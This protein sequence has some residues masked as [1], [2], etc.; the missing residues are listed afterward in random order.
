M[1][2]FK[3]VS[4]R[5]DE[6]MPSPE[7]LDIYR[8]VVETD[9]EIVALADSIRAHGIQ[10]PLVITLDHYILSGHRRHMAARLAG[11]REVPC[12]ILP[13]R[14]ADDLDRY[15]TQLREYNRQRVKTRE[16]LL[17]EAAIDVDPEAAYQQLS[18][19]RTADS[20]KHLKGR[21]KI[22]G[23]KKRAEISLA[24]APMLG[25]VKKIIFD[26]EDHWPLS[27]R[28]VHYMA[29]NDPPLRHASKPDS[30]YRNDRPSY[31]ALCDLLVRARLL[32]IIPWDAISDDTRP[33]ETW[34]IFQNIQPYVTEELKQFCNTYWRD[35]MQS[36]PDHIEIVG[37]KNTLKGTI[38]RTSYQFTIPYTLGRGYCSLDPRYEMAERYRNS[39][40]QKLIVL[41]LG[42]FDPEGED[43]C[44]SFARSMRDDFGIANIEALKVGLTAPQTKKY[45][46]PK[47]MTAKESSARREKFVEKHGEN[48]WEIEAL[49]P[50]TLQE[51]LTDAIESVIDLDAY[52][53]EVM[54]ERKDAAVLEANR[55][56]VIQ[57][58]E[59]GD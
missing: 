43:I 4:I 40:K 59:E 35:L 24:K 3:L 39:G 9:P 52:N 6:I 27:V 54:E 56:V 48:V 30:I 1:A 10:E 21:I 17:K 51:I 14:R 45:R 36:Q 49:P 33:V 12:R 57:Y 29:L 16:E 20:K 37:E 44:H 50:A 53:H 31:A 28:Q 42:D 22:E 18:E 25:A 11:L 58:L 38:H 47:K 19:Y 55:R 2:E 32:G 8:P 46:L 34:R 41:M 26:N 13:F 15:V 23:E 7:N 5:V